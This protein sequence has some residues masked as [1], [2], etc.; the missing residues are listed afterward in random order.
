MPRTTHP[1]SRKAHAPKR[2]TS[3]PCAQQRY[4]RAP[5]SAFT[6]TAHFVRVY[7]LHTRP[8][9]LV[10]VLWVSPRLHLSLQLALAIAET[11]PPAA[12]ML[13][14]EQVSGQIKHGARP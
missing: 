11:T 10:L 5:L 14:E 1:V 4:S 9:L 3:R 2:R 7:V 13:V 6:Q 12:C 8:A